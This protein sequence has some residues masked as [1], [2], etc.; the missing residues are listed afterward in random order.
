[1]YFILP[2]LL[3]PIIQSRKISLTNQYSLIEEIRTL[4][5]N[6]V[7]LEGKPFPPIMLM[8]GGRQLCF[9]GA[10]F[11]HIF[12]EWQIKECLNPVINFSRLTHQLWPRPLKW[13]E[14]R[15]TTEML[16]SLSYVY[17]QGRNWEDRVWRGGGKVGHLPPDTGCTW[18]CSAPWNSLTKQSKVSLT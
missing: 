8:T 9:L 5:R 14:S 16:H 15:R 1:M 4:T 3:H 11:L 17:T 7:N 13:K 10:C 12:L 6:K 2:T 18:I